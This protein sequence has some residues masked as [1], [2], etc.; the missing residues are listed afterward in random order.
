MLRGMSELVG[1][2]GEAGSNSARALEALRGAGVTFESHPSF[3]SLFA[4]FGER[5]REVVVPLENSLAGVVGEVADGLLR[6]PRVAVVGSVLLPIEFVVAALPGHRPRRVLAHPVAAAQCTRA[7]RE[8]EVVPC[9]DT[10]GAA[11]LVREGGDGAVG[12]L[13]PPSAAGLYGLEVVVANALDARSSATRFLQLRDESP[14]ASGSHE[15]SWWA[16]REGAGGWA[17]VVRALVGT[18]GDVL[19]LHARPSLDGAVSTRVLLVE[20]AKGALAPSVQRAMA[21]LGSNARLLGSCSGG[22][23]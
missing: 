9:H 22:P 14:V 11:R 15:R 7:L 17:E 8:Y 18:E 20:L 23:S 12:A 1:I 19:T 4:A 6:A 13:C 3:A 10:A 21:G 2:Q 16:L 5:L